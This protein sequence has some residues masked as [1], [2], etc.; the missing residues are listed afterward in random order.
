[1]FWALMDRWKLADGEA[2]ELIGHPGGPTKAGKRPR[3]KVTGE[4][5][6]L[7]GQLQ[8]IEAALSL[9]VTDTAAWMRRPIKDMPLNGQSPVS[10]ITRNGLEGARAVARQVL[11]AG[12]QQRT[13]V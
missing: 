7:F 6:R 1:V 2:L 12:L 5:A 11:M 8:E 13:S 3:F 9:L 4:E 10:Y